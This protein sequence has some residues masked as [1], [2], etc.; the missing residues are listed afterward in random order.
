MQNTGRNTT[1]ANQDSL[2]CRETGFTQLVNSFLQS[3]SV[4][5]SQ[6]AENFFYLKDDGVLN[7][8]LR[9]RL[10]VI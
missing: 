5:I 8:A 6:K 7:K 9:S 4:Q 2:K 10:L 1:L 3:K